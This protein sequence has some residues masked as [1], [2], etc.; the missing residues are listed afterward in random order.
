[1]LALQV[2]GHFLSVS[3]LKA[4]MLAGAAT[5]FDGDDEN[6]NVNNTFA[7][8]HRVDALGWGIAVLNTLVPGATLRWVTRWMGLEAQAPP[9]P[10]TVLEM[11]S[12]RVLASEVMAFYIHPASAVCG[13]SIADL[14]FPPGAAAMLIVRGEELI[15]PRGTTVLASGDH[16]YVF[17]HPEDGPLVHLL[18]GR[19][20]QE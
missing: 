13:S 6:D 3:Q 16:V 1:M 10:D 7:N 14:P 8:Y 5:I 19:E 4:D 2:S 12:T 15:A 17:S 18:F 9:A 11:T 20:E